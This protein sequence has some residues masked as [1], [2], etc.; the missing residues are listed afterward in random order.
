MLVSC[1]DSETG[2]YET[3]EIKFYAPM[4]DDLFHGEVKYFRK[5]GSVETIENW[6]N[7]KREG[8]RKDFFL[9]GN[10]KKKSF[11]ENNLLSGPVIFF[12]QT[13]KIIEKQYYHN[14]IVSGMQSFNQDGSLKESYAFP[15]ILM[16]S[17]SVDKEHGSHIEILFDFGLTGDIF[18]ELGYESNDGFIAQDT[19]YDL[20]NKR[21]GFLFKPNHFGRNTKSILVHHEDS[22]DS[23]S[24]N[25]IGKDISVWAFETD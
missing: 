20:G 6:L 22:I 3:G 9:N 25:G 21:Y 13:G 15:V 2:Y 4:K 14:G 23:M 10:V 11:Y 7:G 16:Q 1:S 24:A 12:S 17:D 18:I 5:D 19:L 8:V